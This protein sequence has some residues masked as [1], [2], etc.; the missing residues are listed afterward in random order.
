VSC[1]S[2]CLLASLAGTSAARPPRAQE[3]PDEPEVNLPAL[4]STKPLKEDP[5]DDEARKLLK[6]CYDEALG[7]AK[8]L[9]EDYVRGRAG[10]DEV[11][12]SWQR[13]VDAGL[14]LCSKPAERVALL[15]Q[16]VEM[17]KEAEKIAKERYEAG[18]WRIGG[19]HRARYERLDAEIHLL[20]AKRE[21]DA[22]KGK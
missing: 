13:L 8:G 16:Y 2:L 3:L 22:A 12:G 18:R 15:T 20:R 1:L 9:Y 21:A 5:R 7:E 14:E 10:Q 6:A 17:A 4:L 11:Y 19:L